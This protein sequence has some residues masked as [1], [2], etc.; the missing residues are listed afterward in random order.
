MKHKFIVAAGAALVT[1]AVSAFVY[2]KNGSSPMDEFFNANVEA[3]A[4][5]ETEMGAMCSQTGTS[6]SYHMPLCSKCNGVWG[7]YAQ[8]RVAFCN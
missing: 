6:G 8:D 5:T 3:L 1:A 7:N 4:R 2:V